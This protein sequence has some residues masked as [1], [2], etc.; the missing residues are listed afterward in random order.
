M[1][2]GCWVLLF[3]VVAAGAV[4]VFLCYV[5]SVVC[6]FSNTKNGARDYRSAS[7]TPPSTTLA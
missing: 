4:L 3:L 7:S 2:G 5:A 6:R 1:G